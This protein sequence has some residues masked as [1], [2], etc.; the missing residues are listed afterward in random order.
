MGGL[1]IDASNKCLDGEPAGQ[2][3]WTSID[4]SR[5][6]HCLSQSVYDSDTVARFPQSGTD[7]R[8]TEGRADGSRMRPLRY[9]RRWPYQRDERSA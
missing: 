5:L 3:A 2:E 4:C 6:K 8:N 9:D 1:S 7:V